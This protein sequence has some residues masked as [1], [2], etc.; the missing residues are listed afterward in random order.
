[1]EDLL[2]NVIEDERKQFTTIELLTEARNEIRELYLDE[3]DQR[4]WRIGYSGGKDSTLTVSLV[5]GVMLNLPPEQLKRHVYVVGADTG[6]ETPMI[7]EHLKSQ[8]E[9]IQQFADK[10]KLPLTVKIVKRETKDSYFVE[11]LGRG[12]PLPHNGER[13]CTD[14]LKI[15]PQE[16]A[17]AGI[18]VSLVLT[19]VRASESEARSR[20]YDNKFADGEYRPI[21]WFTVENVWE[22]LEAPLPWGSSQSILQ[23]YK[24]ATG[25][26]GFRNPKG[27]EKSKV[28]ACGARFGC[29]ICPVVQQDKSTE[30]LSRSHDWLEPLTE[31]RE[32]HMIVYGHNEPPRKPGETDVERAKTKRLWE[33]INERVKLLTKAG[34]MRNMKQLDEGSGCLIIEARKFLLDKLLDAEQRMNK[35]RAAAGLPPSELIEAD[36]VK[37][38]LAQHVEDA[39]ERPF[40]TKGIPPAEIGKRIDEIIEQ[41]TAEMEMP[42]D[43]ATENLFTLSDAV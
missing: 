12:Y 43:P 28:D 3:K 20:R 23:I 17:T 30:Y 9:Q 11:T 6:V 13:R 38:I 1:M 40:L 33:R 37:E 15:I 2:G 35:L 34:F 22:A 32:L 31:W 16:T 14:K 39:R 24:E 27:T 42:Y 18:D 19:G 29:W 5:A 10:Y 26:C 4:P 36:E 8:A 41:A 7:H 25:E 21:L